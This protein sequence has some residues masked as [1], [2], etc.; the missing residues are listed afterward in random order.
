MYQFKTDT[1]YQTAK[2]TE[3]LMELV[4]ASTKPFEIVLDMFSGGGSTA[5]ACAENTTEVY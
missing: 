2:P 4:K 5:K 1:K 3:L